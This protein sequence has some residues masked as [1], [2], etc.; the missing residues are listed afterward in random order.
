MK[1][2][3][4]CLYKYTVYKKIGAA[5]DVHREMNQGLHFAPYC[6]LLSCSD[7]NGAG[8]TPCMS[9]SLSERKLFFF[10]GLCR[11]SIPIMPFPKT[12]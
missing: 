9:E 7:I 6:H 2:D 11:L 12:I 10:R 1:I 8:H 5:M 3:D 4:F